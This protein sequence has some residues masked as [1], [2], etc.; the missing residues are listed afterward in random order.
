MKKLPF[1]FMSDEF[2]EFVDDTLLYKGDEE[3]DGIIS[4]SELDG[5][6][7]AIISGPSMIMPGQWFPV[8]WGGEEFQPNWESE[9]ELQTFMSCVIE[10]M[11][12]IA[13][14]LTEYPEEF[15]PLFLMSGTEEKTFTIVDDWCEGYMKGVALDAK[16]WKASP[17]EV[18]KQLDHINFFAAE[19]NDDLR[20]QLKYDGTEK[21]RAK[22]EPAA[23][24]IHAYFLKQRAS[25]A[26]PPQF[27]GGQQGQV[28]REQPKIGR[29][30]LCFCGSGKK[31]KKCCLGAL[32][33]V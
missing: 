24:K 21:H 9:D 32:R 8:L 14:C 15:E 13:E 2:I 1:E 26:K 20:E 6:L 17:K 3:S 11:N 25:A 18:L 29:N 22:I 10:H 16:T 7:T 33:L 28:V 19:E 23:K 27:L 5:F 4:I 30:D 31:F 12:S